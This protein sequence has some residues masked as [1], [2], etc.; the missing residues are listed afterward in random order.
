MKEDIPIENLY[1]KTKSMYK[2]VI[3][4]SRRALELNAGAAHLTESETDNV[5]QLALQEII[6]DKVSYKQQKTSKQ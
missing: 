1:E 5:A 2:L 4:A 6:E 3:L